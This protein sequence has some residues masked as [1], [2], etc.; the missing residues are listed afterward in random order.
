M[1]RPFPRLNA[2]AWNAQYRLGVWNYLD[3]PGAGAEML[4]F[5]ERY[6]SHAKILDLGC[7]TSASVPLVPG[8]YRHY[9]GVDIS[10]TAIRQARR[11]KRPDTS[12]E[13]ADIFTYEPDEHYDAI[14]LREVL[15]YFS[16]DEAVELLRRLAR[17]LSADG[18]I[19][20]QV[21]RGGTSVHST[22][23]QFADLVRDCGLM[24]VEERDRRAPDGTADGFLMVLGLQDG[25]PT[26]GPAL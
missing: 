6:S 12:F 3:A 20:V 7:G 17:F 19:F 10:A 25:G 1:L 9:H 4:Q 21:W 26:P 2:A 13:V 5:V 22:P 11:L 18:K 24:V 8:R 23:A 14:L 15:Y 16:A